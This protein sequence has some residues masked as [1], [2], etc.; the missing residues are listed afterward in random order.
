MASN[1]NLRRR[2]VLLRS[3]DQ[4]LHREC[5]EDPLASPTSGEDEIAQRKQE[6]DN[7]QIVSRRD[8][9]S[10]DSSAG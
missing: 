2:S 8:C 3:G 10:K 5:T 1:H 7:L 4:C 6:V 9:P